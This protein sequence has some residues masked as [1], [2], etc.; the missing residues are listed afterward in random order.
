MQ[1][2]K[3]ILLESRP[4][5]RASSLLAG[6]LLIITLA[7][8]ISA[9][10]LA[11]HTGTS[12]PSG[13]TIPL[14]FSAG[15]SGPVRFA[16]QLDRTAVLAGGD[17]LVG[18]E[19]VISADRRAPSLDK[20]M[21]TDLVVILD[22]SG[23]MSGAPLAHAKSAV[24]ELISQLESEDRFAL[25]TY[26]S[27]GALTIPLAT[28]SSDAR[29]VW[30]AALESIAPGGGTHMAQGLDLAAD[31]VARADLRGRSARVILV[32][33]GHANEG[34]HS[35][36]GLRTR[37][38]RAVAGEYVLSTVGVGEGFD[39]VLMMSLADAGTGNFY[40]VQHSEDLSSVF[41]G[42][43]ASARETLASS[44]VVQ[45]EPAKGVEVVDA[46][47]YPLERVAGSVH[48]RLGSLFSG[49]QRRIWV[50]LRAPHAAP[51]A[52]PLGRFA[53]VYAQAG[54][55]RELVF[56][57]MPRVAC[58]ADEEQH[59]ASLDQQSFE[60]QLDVNGVNALKLGV[61]S[62]VQGG[63]AVAALRQIEEFEQ[64]Y[65]GYLRH[66]DR[67]EKDSLAYRE[68]KR[69]KARIEGAFAPQAAPSER[70]LLGKALS[71][72]GI[73]GRRVGAKRK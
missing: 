56:S 15:G 70:N 55:H 53:L 46:A 24:R 34:D 68:A 63:D 50:T 40:Y 14:H 10:V 7:G 73:D 3:P 72:E 62:S 5:L 42:E 29:R 35:P 23:S 44:V 1:G 2:D 59:L 67:K 22:R 21:P 26:A 60:R 41:A 36:S 49:Q 9:R 30:L 28:A 27:S 57:E 25:V 64:L 32:S 31:L 45:I 61:A 39:E 43:F 51:G 48:F 12:P 8:G 71:A 6:A 19:L 16:G 69:L 17:G 33:D 11:W 52:S 37:A 58:V 4:W 20:R 65:R 38:S 54:K 66:F 47:G 13:R 18:M